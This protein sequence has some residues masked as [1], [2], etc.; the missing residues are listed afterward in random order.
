M[1]C[2]LSKVHTG[3][4]IMPRVTHTTDDKDWG[5]V[6]SS[7]KVHVEK[8]ITQKGGFAFVDHVIERK[9]NQYW[10][11]Q[12][13]AFQFWMLGYYKFVGE[14]ETTPLDN[15]GIRIDYIYHLHSK[16]FLLYPFDWLFAKIIW[17]KYMKRVLE[18]VKAMAYNEEI[19]QYD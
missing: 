1:L 14:W 13:D 7:K 11:I 3:Y 16:W 17:R 6:G 2:D 8:S 15:A 12:V 18:N 19:Y 4:G 9:E 10:K 5:Q